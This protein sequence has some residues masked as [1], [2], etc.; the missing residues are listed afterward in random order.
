MIHPDAIGESQLNENTVAIC[1]YVEL[2]RICSIIFPDGLSFTL[3]SVSFTN[4]IRPVWAPI[5]HTL[6]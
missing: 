6:D 2:L 4:I 5:L 1:Y 3:T